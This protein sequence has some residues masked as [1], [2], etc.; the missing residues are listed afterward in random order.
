MAASNASAV[1]HLV[2][3][4][5]GCLGVLRGS[6]KAY[7][8]CGISPNHPPSNSHLVAFLRFI[9]RACSSNSLCRVEMVMRRL[10][11]L[12]FLFVLL[13]LPGAALAAARSDNNSVNAMSG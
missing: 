2:Q 1:Q 6:R 12:G 7:A 4:F 8:P 11:A 13:S 3:A 10:C 9:S 5:M